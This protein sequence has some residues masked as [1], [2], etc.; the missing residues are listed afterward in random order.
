MT[1]EYPPEPWRLRGDLMVSSF[2]VPDAA[3]PTRYRHSI[4]A[5]RRPLAVAGRTVVGVAFVNYRP[6]GQLTYRELL[7]AIPSLGPGGQ[8][9]TIPEIWVDS[10]ESRQG[11]RDLWGIPKELA[12][13]TWQEGQFGPR[14]TMKVAGSTVASLATRVGGPLA[15]GH[16]TVK[17]PILQHADGGGTVLSHNSV[18][19]RLRGLVPSWNFAEDGP[20]AFLAGRRPTASFALIDSS[21]TF[22]E[23]VER[24]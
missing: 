24:S 14:A 7:V 11:G 18:T 1:A 4:P 19:A 23:R 17:L 13:F 9:V 22:G 12:S 6:G 10:P 3:V 2:L 16:R 20:L 8:R 15:P 5:A 21:I